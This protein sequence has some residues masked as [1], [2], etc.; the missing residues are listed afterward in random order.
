MKVKTFASML[1]I[2][3]ANKELEDLG[4]CSNRQRDPAAS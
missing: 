4:I 2:F 1:K 3:Q